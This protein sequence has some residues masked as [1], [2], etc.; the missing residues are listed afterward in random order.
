MHAG[1]RWMTTAIRHDGVWS[2]SAPELVGDVT[3]LLDRLRQ[4]G[5][6]VIVIGFDFPI[7]LPKTYGEKSGLIDFRSALT[8]FGQGVWSDWYSVAEHREDISLHRP[9][10]PRRPGGTKRSH[11]VEGLGLE[12]TDALLRRCERATEDRQAAC[13]LFWTL[14]GNQVGKGAITGWREILTPNLTI[15]GLWPF[16]G[17]L[18]QLLS[19][20]TVVFAE[21]YPASVYSQLGVSRRPLWSK[22]LRNGRTMVARHLMAWLRSRPVRVEPPFITLVSQGFSAGSEGEDQFDAA[23]G[24]F[25]MI[26]VLDG[27]RP[28]GTPKDPAIQRWEGWILG[29]Q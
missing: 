1:K 15:A 20:H 9:F 25:G 23:V 17:N 19:T 21:T 29:Q 24:L 10:Y 27:R 14:G 8:S 6:G 13:M 5:D 28:E 16:D 3:T 4:R 12:S 11:L 2:I 26:D 18:D 7:G 22:R